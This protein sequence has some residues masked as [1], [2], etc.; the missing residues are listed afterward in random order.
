MGL[1]VGGGVEFARGYMV[2]LAVTRP[3]GKAVGSAA[4]GMLSG[5][6]QGWPGN[7]RR[8]QRRHM[9]WSWWRLLSRLQL[10]WQW[11]GRLAQRC[12]WGRRFGFALGTMVC[13]AM[14]L[15]RRI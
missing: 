5:L 10:G 15:A 12:T 2:G 13:L 4:L 14:G 3:V 11:P 1:A 8:V 7:P 9:A 6:W